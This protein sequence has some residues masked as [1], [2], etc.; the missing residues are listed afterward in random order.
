MCKYLMGPTICLAVLM[1]SCCFVRPYTLRLPGVWAASREAN[2]TW[3]VGI[4]DDRFPDRIRQISAPD[5]Y[6]MQR[7]N[8]VRRYASLGTNMLIVELAHPDRYGRSQCLLVY[9]PGKDA[10]DVIWT[11]S[12]I[13]SAILNYGKAVVF[14]DLP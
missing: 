14:V 3:V 11:P 8:E 5:S 6:E 12:E 9:S 13:D 2:R 7:R 1:T 10:V 4:A